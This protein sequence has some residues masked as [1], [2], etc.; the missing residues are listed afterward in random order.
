M[1]DVTGHS[2]GHS[3]SVVISRRTGAIAVLLLAL[4]PQIIDVIWGVVAQIARLAGNNPLTALADHVS[5]LV[6]GALALA[7]FVFV[8]EAIPPKLLLAVLYSYPLILIAILTLFVRQRSPQDYF[9]GIVLVAIG[10]FAFWASSDLQGMRGFT[11]GPGTA[12]RMFSILL[13]LLGGGVAITGL[14]ADGPPLQRYGIRG[15]FFVSLAI[16]AF[17]IL[18]RPM[19]LVVTA[20]ASFLIAAMGSDETKWVEAAIVGACLTL[21]C[22]LLFPYALG[23]PLQLWPRFLIQ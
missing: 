4:A 23:L 20:F 3:N 5:A 9:G 22:S 14:M 6:S 19:G 1:S 15:P 11:F 18:I 8:R 10:L 17:A 7:S 21:F 16:I 2:P 12:P 13:V